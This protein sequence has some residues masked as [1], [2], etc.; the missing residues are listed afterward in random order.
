MGGGKKA[1]AATDMGVD[2][3][4]QFCRKDGS[5]EGE[6]GSGSM[7]SEERRAVHGSDGEKGR[8]RSCHSFHGERKR[9]GGGGMVWKGD[10]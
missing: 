4:I 3:L 6:R 10:F 1:A 8:R 9:G 7:V 5:L 2:G